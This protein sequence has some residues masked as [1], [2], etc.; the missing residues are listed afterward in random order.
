M[1]HYIVILAKKHTIKT[2][3]LSMILSVTMLIPAQ[4]LMLWCSMMDDMETPISETMSMHNAKDSENEGHCNTKDEA[5]SDQQNK[6]QHC[7]ELASCDCLEIQSGIQ[8]QAFVFANSV[9]SDL[10]LSVRF[11][12][13][14][15]SFEAINE[16]IPPPIW[17][18]S[19]YSPPD[20]FLAN[21]SFL[22]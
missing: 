16:S 7:D 4:E 10:E 22:I 12:Q 9:K 15:E 3:T 14:V 11:L 6:D 1:Y 17:S 13:L 8:D 18:F 5:S 21:A 2:I 19:S 20:L